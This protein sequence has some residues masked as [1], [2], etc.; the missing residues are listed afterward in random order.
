MA[1]HRAK[2]GKK[3]ARLQG[4][5]WEGK[6]MAAIRNEYQ[7]RTTTKKGKRETGTD[8]SYKVGK[9]EVESLLGGGKKPS[10]N[11]LTGKRNGVQEE[12]G[13]REQNWIAH[14]T[15]PR[16]NDIKQQKK[17]TPKS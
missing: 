10:P 6:S 17:S 13:G 8:F 3:H 9:V 2:R 12:G 1:L 5:N 11:L 15:I 14:E 16:E 7:E 4:R